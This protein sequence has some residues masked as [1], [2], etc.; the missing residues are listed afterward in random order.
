MSPLILL[1][2]EQFTHL[3]DC[4]LLLTLPT[5]SA[6]ISGIFLYLAD[7][8][9]FLLYPSYNDVEILAGQGT[10]AMEILEQLDGKVDAVVIPVGG[11]GLLAGM[12]TVFKHL[13][14]HVK[15]IVS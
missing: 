8:Q 1:C 5:I 14:P 9:T 2:L 4:K 15:V 11:G 6:N 3:Y 7:M 13:A 10:A 12:A